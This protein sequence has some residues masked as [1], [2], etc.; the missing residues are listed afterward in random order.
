MQDARSRVASTKIRIKS[1]IHVFDAGGHNPRHGF[2]CSC[3]LAGYRC[4]YRWTRRWSDAQDGTSGRSLT[5]RWHPSEGPSVAGQQRKQ[6]ATRV[7]P[8][9]LAGHVSASS[10]HISSGSRIAQCVANISHHVCLSPLTDRT[11]P[12]TRNPRLAATHTRRSPQRPAAK[13]RKASASFAS[14]LVPLKLPPP[15]PPAKL[16]KS[17]ALDAHMGL[18]VDRISLEYGRPPPPEKARKASASVGR[19]PPEK[20]R[21]SS[22]SLLRPPPP[23]RKKSSASRRGAGGV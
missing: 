20:A 12:C 14:G 2:D 13:L 7:P 6:S 11:K 4:G 22:A 1:L 5:T 9:A 21:K 16:R 8:S 18:S 10:R 3:A 19:R 23:Q 15:L 17:S